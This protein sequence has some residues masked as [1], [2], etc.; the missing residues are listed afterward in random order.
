MNYFSD[1]SQNG[2]LPLRSSHLSTTATTHPDRR[3]YVSYAPNNYL[4]QRG[5]SIRSPPNNMSAITIASDPSR[6]ANDNAPAPFI[7]PSRGG[8]TTLRNKGLFF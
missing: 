6:I 5:A 3:Q 7:T 8:K 1:S 2:S 4:Q